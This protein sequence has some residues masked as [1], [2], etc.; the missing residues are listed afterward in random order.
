[1]TESNEI[2]AS[3]HRGYVIDID[4]ELYFQQEK[5]TFNIVNF[6][7]LNPLR[8]TYKE[9]FRNAIDEIIDTFNF[10]QTFNSRCTI[11]ALN[12]Q[13]EQLDQDFTFILNEAIKKVAGRRKSIPYSVEKVKRLATMKY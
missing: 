9:Q 12:Q 4:L 11:T 7:I 10:K 5:N 1:L 8:R 6:E 2:A 13:L 3:D